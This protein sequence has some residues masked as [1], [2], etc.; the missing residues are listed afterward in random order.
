MG[1]VEAL[2]MPDNEDRIDPARKS[3]E[4]PPPRRPSYERV[5]ANIEKWAYSSGLQKPS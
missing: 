5:A 4:P 2:A 1:R 3:R